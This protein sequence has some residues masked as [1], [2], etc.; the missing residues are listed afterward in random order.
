[1]ERKHLQ[2]VETVR[3]VEQVKGAA[4]QVESAKSKFEGAQAQLSY[5]EVRSPIS[6]IIADRPLYAGEMAS[7]GAPLL[8]VMNIS[9]GIARANVP[10]AQAA[11]LKAGQSARI[12]QT[13]ASRQATGKV[14]LCSPAVDPNSTTVEVWVEAANPAERLKPGATVRVDIHAETEIGRASCRE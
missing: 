7:A 11:I 3:R 5:S 8:T 2:A 9:R 4:A 12:T 13:D 1:M 10:V 6:G 14:T